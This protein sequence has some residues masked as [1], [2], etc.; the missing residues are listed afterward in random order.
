MSR[1][2]NGQICSLTPSNLN[3]GGKRSGATCHMAS[4]LLLGEGSEATEPHN[5]SRLTIRL[6]RRERSNDEPQ[7]LRS[8]YLPDDIAHTTFDAAT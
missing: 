4:M 2:V 1:R 7:P 5:M 6:A 8:K 3:A